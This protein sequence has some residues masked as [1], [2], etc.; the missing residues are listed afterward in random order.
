[1]DLINENQINDNKEKKLKTSLI[2]VLILFF[3]LIIVAIIIYF[4]SQK[5]INEQFKVLIDGVNSNISPT[6]NVFIFDG[7]KTYISIKD[8]APLLSYKVYNG[9][10]KQYT[11]DE[12][13]CYATNS[14]ELV[15]FSAQDTKIRKYMLLSDSESQTFDL[16]EPIMI[17][18]NNLYISE[19]GL[20]K[21]FNIIMEYDKNTN[22]ISLLTLPYIVQSYEKAIPDASLSNN[23]LSKSAIFNNQKALLSNL[24]VVRDSSTNLYGV[25][26]YQNGE[27]NLVI[28]ERYSSIEFI[29]GINDFIVQT[30]DGKYGII[31]NDGIT[32]VRPVYD[33]I[34]EINK[35]LGLYLVISNNKQ[36]VIN[37]NG[38]IIVYQDY[39]K[40]GLENTYNDNNVTN[41]YILFDNCIPVKLN[42]KWGFFDIN[43]NQIVE[44]IY[45]GI[46]CN[47]NL[48]NSTGVIII[49]DLNGIV[50]KKD[51]TE[52]NTTISKYGIINSN[53][54]LI[55]NIVADSAYKTTLE[56]KTTYYLTTQ[57]QV[58]DI[59][60]F[61][62]QS[63]NNSSGSTEN[64]ETSNDIQ[65]ENQ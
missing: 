42:G 15:T 20:E 46:G 41:K 3:L 19:T 6:S 47:T 31:G 55:V 39:D 62:Y 4:Y 53:G 59:V 25:K 64:Q 51:N 21:A 56:N 54:Q 1:M 48:A 24:V 63:Q 28:T 10:Y 45:D 52:N 29:E 11:E 22:T 35:D 26:L 60:S 33:A 8:I 36:G 57:N 27:A 34:S 2:V 50:I 17:R 7:D 32:K 5:V 38:K 43:G 13:S 49:P 37:Q 14:S 61:W 58:I 65:T 16:D 12:S 30:E 9:E 18:G 23:N 40:I 44:P